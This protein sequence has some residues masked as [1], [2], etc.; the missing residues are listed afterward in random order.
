[1]NQFLLCT[2]HWHFKDQAVIPEIRRLNSLKS[3]DYQPLLAVIGGIK[4]RKSKAAL[5]EQHVPHVFTPGGVL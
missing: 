4:Q 1:M 5:L 2:E 3:F